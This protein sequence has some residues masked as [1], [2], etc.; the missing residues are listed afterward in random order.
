M[1]NKIDALSHR[2]GVSGVMRSALSDYAHRAKSLTIPPDYA[3]PDT[4]EDRVHMAVVLTPELRD[5]YEAIAR[6]LNIPV[7]KLVLRC[8]SAYV[9]SANRNH[10][11][12]NHL[13]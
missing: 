10:T 3:P 4:Y 5:K 8:L 9:S 12:A 6:D 7:A 11:E 1:R 2:K 13:T